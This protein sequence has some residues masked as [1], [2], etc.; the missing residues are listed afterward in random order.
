MTKLKKYIIDRNDMNTSNYENNK[1]E[2]YYVRKL[3]KINHAKQ[4][5]HKNIN[6]IKIL[7]CAK[8]TMHALTLQQ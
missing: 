3:A 7:V 1:Y 4:H 8:A 5:I 6:E 2:L